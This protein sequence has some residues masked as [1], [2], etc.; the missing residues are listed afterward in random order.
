MT[1]KPARLTAERSP[2]QDGRRPCAGLTSASGG[3]E[4]PALVRAENLN[5]DILVPMAAADLRV[6]GAQP[7][8]VR[9]QF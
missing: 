5:E 8:R 2:A 4:R 7:L 9:T 1:T 3:G 6:R